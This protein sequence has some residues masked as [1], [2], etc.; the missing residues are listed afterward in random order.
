MA[1]YPEFLMRSFGMERAAAGGQFGTIFL[2]AGSLGALAG[3]W[4]VEPLARR[5][6][7]DAPMRIILGC[8]VLW[9]LPATLGPL[10][11]SAGLAIIAACPI[12]FFLNAYFGVGIAGV[13]L[14]T[15][16]RMRAQVSALMLFSTNL[17]GLAFGPSAVALLTDFMFGDDLMLRY[18]LLVLPLLVCPLAAVLVMQGMRD[19]RSA[20]P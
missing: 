20:L 15:P 11:S 3:G 9:L 14:I 17:F 18:S 5:G 10:S 4:S 2:V 8:A 13:Q 16:N 12:I 7:R 1:W 19:Y 6:Y